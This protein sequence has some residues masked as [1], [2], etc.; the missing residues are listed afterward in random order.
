[1]IQNSGCSEMHNH[2]LAWRDFFLVQVEDN[3]EHKSS[4]YFF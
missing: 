1:M 4:N 2:S 3:L